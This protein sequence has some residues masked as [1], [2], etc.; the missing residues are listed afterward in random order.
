MAALSFD[1]NVARSPGSPGTSRK[2]AAVTGGKA[3]SATGWTRRAG[4]GPVLGSRTAHPPALDPLASAAK[5]VVDCKKHVAVQA[6]SVQV[7]CR[8]AGRQRHLERRESRLCSHLERPDAARRNRGRRGAV[9]V[10][11]GELVRK[12]V[13][14]AHED[15]GRIAIEKDAVLGSDRAGEA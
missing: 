15:D 11:G 7:H 12:G 14:L 4:I 2:S 10:G 9:H 13:Q 1:V 6:K 8:R 5:G 3:E